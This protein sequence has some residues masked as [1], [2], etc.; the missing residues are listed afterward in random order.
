MI[1]KC[2][3]ETDKNLPREL[4]LILSLQFPPSFSPEYHFP[5]EEFRSRE[6]S[7]S[8]SNPIFLFKQSQY[9]PLTAT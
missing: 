2:I 6:H 7:G 5:A 4:Q 1:G 3:G 8:F 9:V